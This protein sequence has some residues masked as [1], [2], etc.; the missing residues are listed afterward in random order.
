MNDDGTLRE[1]TQNISHLANLPKSV[2]TFG[3][4]TSTLNCN[5]WIS[6]KSMT[7]EARLEI[8]I[9]ARCQEKNSRPQ[10]VAE[11]NAI[12]RDIYNDH[13]FWR[14]LN[15]ENRD[16]YEDALSPMWRYFMH[17]LCEATTAT[18]SGSFLETRTYAVGRLLT[19]L[20]GQLKNLQK[21]R[22]KE[23]SRQIEPRIN[24]DGSVT[25]PVNELPDSEPELALRQFEAFLQLL[26]AD[27]TGELNAEENT[28]CGRE[29]AYTLTAQTYLLMRHRDEKTIQQIADE[30]D[31]PRGS[32]QGGSKP[33]KWK[34]LERK[35]AQMAMDS[36]SE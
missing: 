11:L 16:Y 8:W 29:E 4:V 30:I 26:E 10:R 28:L 32:L 15:N 19:Y 7:L 3:I 20:D 25:E 13:R 22:Q 18:K 1:T 27:P 34:A 33:K 12:F 14:Y 2:L 35:L 31:I 23:A 21:Q 5:N 17:N 6:Y 9:T 36:I 24:D